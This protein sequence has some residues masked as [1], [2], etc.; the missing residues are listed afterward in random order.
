MKCSVCGK[1]LV[2]GAAFCMFC[3]SPTEKICPNCGTKLP[4]D[5]TFCYKCGTK[6]GEMPSDEEQP[7]IN[8]SDLENQ[9]EITGITLLSDDEYEAVADKVKIT[10][11]SWSGKW[12]LRSPGYIGRSAAFVNGEDGSVD[13]CGDFVE[14]EFG[15]RPALKISNLESSNLQIGD[16]I[17]VAGYKWT[18]IPNDMA[19]CDSIIAK[20]PF[21]KDGEAADADNYDV[22]D[23]KKYIENWWS[24]ADADGLKIIKRDKEIRDKKILNKEKMEQLSSIQNNKKETV[25]PS[26]PSGKPVWDHSSGGGACDC[27]VG[28]CDCDGSIWH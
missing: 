6:V 4:A 8:T 25:A 28:E 15:V 16:K 27:A 7:V 19:L 23:V 11:F 12:W 18:V 21:R 10:A 5:A 2:E 1:E 13:D 3:G 20:G 22:S 9:I 14:E 24:E 26:K 17:E